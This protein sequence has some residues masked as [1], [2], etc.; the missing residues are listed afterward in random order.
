M[1]LELRFFRSYL[2]GNCG[3]VSLFENLESPYKYCCDVLVNP[4]LNFLIT[5]PFLLLK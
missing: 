5:D 3:V 2:R 1:H 4:L